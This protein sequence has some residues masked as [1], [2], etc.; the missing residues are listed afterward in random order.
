MS[1]FI[2][3]EDQN[4]CGKTIHQQ[5]VYTFT[6][7]RPI[8]FLCIRKISK[9]GPH[10]ASRCAVFSLFMRSS[11]ILHVAL[12][13]TFEILREQHTHV[14]Q[15]STMHSWRC[16]VPWRRTNAY[17]CVSL[18]EEFSSEK[19]RW[20]YMYCQR[21]FSLATLS[22]TRGSSDRRYRRLAR[23]IVRSFG[24]ESLRRGLSG[25]ASSW[26]TVCPLMNGTRSQRRIA[27]D[28]FPAQTSRCSSCHD[29]DDAWRQH[30]H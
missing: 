3:L 22:S 5:T 17:V 8:G 23:I 15:C 30:Q 7:W 18:C 6:E 12:K 13:V 9:Y 10:G 26:R 20:Q 4:I 1:V 29:D 24:R 11:R 21:H 28:C 27:N 2:C 16:G 19:W 25:F 14:S